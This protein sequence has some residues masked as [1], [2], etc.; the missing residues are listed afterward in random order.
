MTS[1]DVA[2]AHSA[3]TT[4][5]DMADIVRAVNDAEILAGVIARHGYQGEDREDLLKRQN[6]HLA[7]AVASIRELLEA[8]LSLQTLRKQAQAVLMLRGP[9]WGTK[10][11]DWMDW[12]TPSVLEN[13]A[14]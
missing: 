3:P 10:D 6:E 13:V 11:G 12:A 1:E 14:A 2:G 7:T 5:P 8:P 4:V 9:E